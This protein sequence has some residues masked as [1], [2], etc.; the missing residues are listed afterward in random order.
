MLQMIRFL[1][2]MPADRTVSMCVC[3]CVCVYVCVCAWGPDGIYI[4]TC[5]YRRQALCAGNCF[6]GKQ[7]PYLNPKPSTCFLC[8]QEPYHLKHIYMYIC[9]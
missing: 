8:K 3:V 7:E 2:A 4:Y 5:V 6:L 1:L 9:I